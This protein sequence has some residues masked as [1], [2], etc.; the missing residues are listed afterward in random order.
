M[1]NNCLILLGVSWPL[2]RVLLHLL[3]C[4][5]RLCLGTGSFSLLSVASK[6]L[7][8]RRV[9]GLAWAKGAEYLSAVGGSLSVDCSQSMGD[10][11]LLGESWFIPA[12]GASDS[13]EDG[14]PGGV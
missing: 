13:L 7:A 4:L 8:R 12:L 1:A 5:R 9:H 3:T 2:S 6:G 14:E 11:G 10:R